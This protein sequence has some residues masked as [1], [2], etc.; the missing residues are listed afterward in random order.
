MPELTWELM[1]AFLA[2]LFIGI[3]FAIM[4]SLG[5]GLQQFNI[6]GCEENP[7]AWKF[8]C[9]VSE[10]EEPDYL[11]AKQSFQ[12]LACAINAVAQ[13]NPQLCSGY[14]VTQA[15]FPIAFAQEEK[16][17]VECRTGE[18][19]ILHE[20]LKVYTTSQKLC[21]E[22]AKSL[23]EKYGG[24]KGD[25][26]LEFAYTDIGEKGWICLC[27]F[28]YY[29]P[30]G[31]R[32]I[33]GIYKEKILRK[34]KNILGED[35]VL[36]DCVQI[37][38]LLHSQRIY[39]TFTKCQCNMKDENGKDISFSVYGE[40]ED[41]VNK[42]CADFE[43][44]PYDSEKPT[45]LIFQSISNCQEIT[46]NF[47]LYDDP[48][49]NEKFSKDFFECIPV[50]GSV[51]CTVKNFNLPEKYAGLFDKAEEYIA[52]FGD[53][54]FLVYF[55]SFPVGEDEDWAGFSPWFETL[56][57]WMFLGFCL[58][59]FVRP[60]VATVKGIKG[61]MTV[62]GIT[63]TVE[64]SK[65]ISSAT[66]TRISKTIEW[67]ENKFKTVEKAEEKLPKIRLALEEGEENA[68]KILRTNFEIFTNAQKKGITTA[69]E[70][71]DFLEKN[72]VKLTEKEKE[73]IEEI[74]YQLKKSPLEELGT[75][76]KATTELLPT[77][78]VQTE[79]GKKAIEDFFTRMFEKAKAKI[80][81]KT[82]AA[83]AVRTMTY[84]GIDSLG[85]YMLSR[86]DSEI[87]KFDPN[88]HEGKL[89]LHRPFKPLEDIELED[90]IIP[91][92]NSPESN[93]LPLKKPIILGRSK[94]QRGIKPFYLASPCHADL[95]IKPEQE[96]FCADYV[97]DTKK[98]FVSCEGMRSMDW[99]GKLKEILK[100]FGKCGSLYKLDKTEIWPTVTAIV[101]DP[102]KRKF[103]VEQI[104][105]KCC[106]IN[107][108]KIWGEC[109][110][111]TEGCTE[112]P[113]YLLKIKNPVT[114]RFYYYN[115][116]SQK[117]T[118]YK[119]GVNLYLP[120]FS[121]CRKIESKDDFDVI[122]NSIGFDTPLMH[123]DISF[124]ENRKDVIYGYP[125]NDNVKF[126]SVRTDILAESST[127][128]GPEGM[129]ITSNSWIHVVI[130]DLNG[131]KNIDSIFYANQEI[132][133]L[134]SEIK[135]FS[136][137]N[138]NDFDGKIDLVHS[139]NCKI[140]AIDIEVDT[141]AYEDKPNYCYRKNYQ[142][143]VD[144]ATMVALFAVDAVVKSIKWAGRET[145]LAAIATEI[146]TT[147]VDCGLAY[148]EFR[149]LHPEWPG[150]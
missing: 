37:S 3:I 55:Q 24:K 68:Q 85:A 9:R 65:E 25:K 45:G 122:E 48:D 128:P 99:S 31:S 150:K 101:K 39:S 77:P 70:Y 19:G 123:C 114:G 131:D 46:G 32:W 109:Q 133:G 90:A 50:E 26:P 18:E 98:G 145:L 27:S 120:S 35:A 12:A 130:E 116:K 66:K 119:E 79:K 53:P 110:I 54:S 29:S 28:E 51:E 22:Y 82:A 92:S 76:T 136:S 143:A 58:G 84:T 36:A 140:D 7:P 56:G 62:E 81:P 121:E 97:Y 10:A 111:E 93:I 5:G 142:S 100:G 8:W 74:W 43:I 112:K 34:C 6:F 11:I 137:F 49:I 125:E 69:G 138:D 124:D 113:D 94:W 139:S 42:I 108:Q 134:K 57:K 40:N 52:G 127:S 67:L 148:V 107:G 88:N 132:M 106:D 61:L 72:G 38:T 115:P 60:V 4:T 126:F 21:E 146:V 17:T 41:M 141:E 1:F 71:I 96:V 87:N 44:N 30:L 129:P 95:T 117:I 89:V 23:N 78:T 91:S 47:L 144:I 118:F 2:L 16:A 20:D 14:S 63:K 80:D 104:E 33:E 135:Y 103:T 15:A 64:K 59:H 86:I 75:Q 149:Y 102:Q 147:A 13:G 83:A 73:L 105:P